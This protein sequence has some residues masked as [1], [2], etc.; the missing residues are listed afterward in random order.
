M[1]IVVRPPA[2]PRPVR[3]G[4]GEFRVRQ[5]TRALTYEIDSRLRR[6]HPDTPIAYSEREGE[7]LRSILMGFSGVFLSDGREVL[8]EKGCPGC[9]GTGKGAEG[10]V[11]TWCPKGETPDGRLVP[12]CGDIRD[13][14][15]NIFPDEL[16]DLLLAEARRA[17]TEEE[18]PGK[19]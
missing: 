13:F 4:G 19:G 14:A 17:Q 10:A 2:E 12:G 7:V 18:A 3:F 6:L 8:W 9:G 15:V 11:C 16:W 5:L 1:R